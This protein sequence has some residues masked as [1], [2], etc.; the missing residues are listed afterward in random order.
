M[1]AGRGP[2]PYRPEALGSAPPTAPSP[3]SPPA[4]RVSAATVH[5]LSR[6]TRSSRES[7]VMSN[8]AKCRRSCCGVTMPLWCSPRNAYALRIEFLGAVPRPA[9]KPATPATAAAPAT[10]PATPSTA[11][12]E[13]PVEAS[14]EVSSASGM[15]TF[16]SA[17]VSL[18]NRRGGEL[19]ERLAQRVDGV[20]ELL[21]LL[22]REFGVEHEAVLDRAVLREQRV[23]VIEARR[24]ES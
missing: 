1:P 23:E 19:R 4:I 24:R 5:A 8:A 21:D 14:L 11:L 15:G 16:Y 9:L 7:L 12:R 10:A 17:E 13:G 3:S 6:A 18:R 2:R 20:G 22:W